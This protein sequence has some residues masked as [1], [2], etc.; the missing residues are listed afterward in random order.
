MQQ[1]TIQMTPETREKVLK[2]LRERHRSHLRPGEALEC[3]GSMNHG[4]A[5]A[6]LV[7][8]DAAEEQVLTLQGKVDLIGN[9]IQSPLDGLHAV[10]DLLDLSLQEY[11]AAG[12]NWRPDLDW[13]PHTLPQGE[14][15]VWT[16]GRL[17]NLKV[18]RMAAELLGEALEPDFEI[19]P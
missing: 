12:R 10:L 19:D 17:R 3:E 1:Q 5:Q 2:A 4:E 14:H 9:D 18:E 16:R 8:R 15:E 11:F 13:K 6:Q 7:L